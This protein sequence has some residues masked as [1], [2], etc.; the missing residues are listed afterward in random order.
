MNTEA[1]LF[2]FHSEFATHR[3]QVN[4]HLNLANCNKRG[5]NIFLTL[6]DLHRER[7]HLVGVFLSELTFFLLALIPEE[8]LI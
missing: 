2:Y 3:L 5:V 7:L 4:L 1:E 8:N 6:F